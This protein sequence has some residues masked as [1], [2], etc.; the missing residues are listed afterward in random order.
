MIE[1]ARQALA[2]VT[3]WGILIERA[4]DRSEGVVQVPEAVMHRASR[5]LGKGVLHLEDGVVPV[6][7]GDP[8][9]LSQ[10]LMTNIAA[11]DDEL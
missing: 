8:T 10:A 11:L 1:A 6:D 9:Q 2:L 4:S 5:E 3:A 7:G